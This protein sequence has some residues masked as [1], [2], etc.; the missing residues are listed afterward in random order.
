MREREV[1]CV[2]EAKVR[3]GME[4]KRWVREGRGGL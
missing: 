3:K 2:M 1:S 4:E